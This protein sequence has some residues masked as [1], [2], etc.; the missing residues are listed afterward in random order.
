MSKAKAKT[1]TKAVKQP[2]GR[3]IVSLPGKPGSPPDDRWVEDRELVLACVNYV[4]AVAAYPAGFDVDPDGNNVHAQTVFYSHFNREAHLRV[5]T[6]T[7][8][9]TAGGL[10]AKA[11]A[12]RFFL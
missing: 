8:A 11:A 5:M 4:H 3:A 10:Y 9:K 12:M 7:P 1:T 2:V 6:K